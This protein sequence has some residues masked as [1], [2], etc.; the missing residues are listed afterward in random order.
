M[1]EFHGRHT[2]FLPHN[3]PALPF[4]AVSLTTFFG[5]VREIMNYSHGL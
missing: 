5:T 3:P 4:A 2:G 1:N